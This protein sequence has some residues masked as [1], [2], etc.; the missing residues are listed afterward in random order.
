MGTAVV[1][2][3][4]SGLGHEL[5]HLLASRGERVVA[6]ARSGDV[7]SKLVAASPRIEC[8][9][10]DLATPQGRDDLA[11]AVDEVDILVN[12]AGLGA[13]G[14]F[15]DSPRAVS[16]QMVE[17]NV[18]ALTDLTARWLPGMVARRAGRVVNVASTA[19]FQPGPKM[20][21]YYATKAYVLSFTEAIA[22]ELRGTGV[23]ATAFCPGPFASGFQS[24]AGIESSSLLRG[25]RLPSSGEMARAAL[26]AMDRGMVVCVPGA[27]NRAGAVAP[28]LVPRFLVRRMVAR[29]QSDM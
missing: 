11:A 12:N 24:V 15:A 27:L 29:I 14:S 16:D 18:A 19:A 25:R 17:V 26:S 7:L 23:T 5:A 3:A 6:V 10:A 2:G 1:T 13:S 20:A 22:E 9:V 21:V 8:V 28:R 4:S